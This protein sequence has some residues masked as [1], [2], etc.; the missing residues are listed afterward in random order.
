MLNEAKS[1]GASFKVI[2]SDSP[3]LSSLVLENAL[4]SDFGLSKEIVGPVKYNCTTAF[5]LVLPVFLMVTLISRNSLKDLL[6]VKRFESS[7]V[8]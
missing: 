1:F 5:P 3:G 8:V 2:T 7:K 4:S 6:L